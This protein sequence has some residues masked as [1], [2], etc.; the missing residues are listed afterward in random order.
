MT[1]TRYAVVTTATRPGKVARYLPGNYYV[2]AEVIVTLGTGNAPTEQVAATLIR[3][4]DVAG[5][6]LDDYVLPRLA[7]GLIFAREVTPKQTDA[8][9]LKAETGYDRLFAAVSG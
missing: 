7:S 6:T 4:V 2:A 9:T 5:W 8:D 3:G 1:P